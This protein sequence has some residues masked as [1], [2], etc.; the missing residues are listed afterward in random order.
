MHRVFRRIG[1]L[2]ASVSLAACS[3]VHT[4]S[5]ILIS[6]PS[7]EGPPVN[8]IRSQN[9]VERVVAGGETS[10]D[11]S[12]VDHPGGLRTLTTEPAMPQPK[13]QKRVART[14]GAQPAPP[15]H[16]YNSV[17]TSQ[18]VVAISF[19]DG[20]HPELTPKLLDILKAR[21]IRA[22]F[23]VIG[24]NVEAYPEIA[25]RIV[26]EGHEIANH[27]WSHPS[28]TKIGAAGVAREIKRTTEV[29]Q[30]V[31]GVTP[32]TMRPPYGA[33]N[34]SINR[35]MNEEFGLRVA[36]W[37]VDPQDWKYRNAQRVANHLATQTKAGDILLAHDIHPSTIAAMP[38]ALDAL[39]AKGLRFVTVE[40]LIA[41]DEAPV[42]ATPT[43]ALNRGEA[44]AK[45]EVQ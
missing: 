27:T 6:D 35:R 24:R 10:S 37:S 13:T 14:E 7:Q 23:Y 28:L 19:D 43:V 8:Q 20:P 22:T 29:I 16:A 30:R 5:R 36:M 33:T 41:L 40:E 12:P 21:N 25:R 4:Q 38:P 32:T 18:P 44:E 42:P 15:R 26:A 31:T 34:A 11:G 39:L 45:P 17:N 1:W 9:G 2:V 3:S